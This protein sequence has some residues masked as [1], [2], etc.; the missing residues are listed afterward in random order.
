MVRWPIHEEGRASVH[1]EYPKSYALGQLPPELSII[2][3][4]HL[5]TCTPC[6]ILLEET[7]A[8][9]GRN[10]ASFQS[11]G[12]DNRK[13]P[14]VPAD[15][16]ATIVILQPAHSGNFA[17]RVLDISKEGM[18]LLVPGALTRGTTIQIRLRDLFILA[19][20]RYCLPADDAFHAGVLIQDVFAMSA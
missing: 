15:D 4:F 13:S 2:N 10:T 20:V 12:G 6:S 14:R 7:R 3:N 17:T 11:S 19:E 8:F 9:I 16:A 1:I 18:K 5:T